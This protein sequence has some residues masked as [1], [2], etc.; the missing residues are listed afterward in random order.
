MD[1]SPAPRP[2]VAPLGPVVDDA[3]INEL[4]G[5]A[6]ERARLNIFRT[7]VQN[8]RVFKRWVPFGHILLNGQLP[9]R[10]R[11]LLILRTAHRCGSPY[12]WGHHERIALE[13]GLAASDIAGV[14][15]G[16]DFA[17]WSAFDAAL[18][19]AVDELLDDRSISEATWA[20]LAEKYDARLLIEVPMLVGHYFM[21]AIT[22]NSLGVEP[23]HDQ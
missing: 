8:P 15:E 9:V 22:L 14:R 12:E 7:L 13:E 2:R 4:L 10:D 6:G 20:M 19:R 23:E 17:G 16:P 11:E 18:V 5:M 3:Q 21:L 1:P